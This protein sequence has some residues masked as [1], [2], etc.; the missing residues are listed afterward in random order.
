MNRR[1]FLAGLSLIGI[2]TACAPIERTPIRGRGL[3]QVPLNRV[4]MTAH[5]LDIRTIERER[6]RA[7]VCCP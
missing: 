1:T 7:A 6:I 3:G 4:Q 5:R 2:A